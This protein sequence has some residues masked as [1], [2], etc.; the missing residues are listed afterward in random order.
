MDTCA[1]QPDKQLYSLIDNNLTVLR[2]FM[3]TKI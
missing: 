3:I 1:D 2:N